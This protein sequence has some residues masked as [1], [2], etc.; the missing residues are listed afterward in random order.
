M[1]RSQV[2]TAPVGLLPVAA[3]ANGAHLVAN[4]IDPQGLSHA[5]EVDVSGPTGVARA[6]PGL[7][8]ES[9]SLSIAEGISRDG[10]TVLVSVDLASDSTV[11]TVPWV[12]G[13]PVRIANETDTDGAGWNG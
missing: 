8:G 2:K 12:G 7:P 3:S 6:V 4:Y 11:D 9:T 10:A 13:A 5:R 1:R